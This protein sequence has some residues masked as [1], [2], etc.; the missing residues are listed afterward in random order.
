MRLLH[1]RIPAEVYCA[2]SEAPGI[3]VPQTDPQSVE[4]V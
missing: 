1:M 3:G 4:V 2:Q